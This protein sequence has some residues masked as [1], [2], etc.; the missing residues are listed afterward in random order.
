MSSRWYLYEAGG[1]RQLD[2]APDAPSREDLYRPWPLKNRLTAL[3]GEGPVL[4]AGLN[5][6]GVLRIDQ[7]GAGL[8]SARPRFTVVSTPLAE[9]RTIGNLYRDGEGL[10]LQFY[11]DPV[12]TPETPPEGPPVRL[13]RFSPERSRWEPVGVQPPAEE[14]AA[15]PETWELA[16]LRCQGTQRYVWWKGG[17]GR[18]T[19][20]LYGVYTEAFH[21]FRPLSRQLWEERQREIAAPGGLFTTLLRSVNGG[22]ARTGV[23]IRN[24][25]PQT[26]QYR[27]LLNRPPERIGLAQK[28]IVTGTLLTIGE[29]RF[30]MTERGAFFIQQGSAVLRLAV[31]MPHPAIRIID[32]W[33]DGRMVWA[34]WEERRFFQVGASG[35]LSFQIPSD[36]NP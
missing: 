1:I 21:R 9:N 19:R 6:E 3:L 13:L 33:T 31:E 32:F 2:S 17:S 8:R 26:G 11:R 24:K 28:K 4:W 14:S 12:F 30:L 27:E 22:D 15:A 10:L 23:I 16:D 7:N 20:R 5:G 29:R 36:K 34:I 25:D 18:D 35:L